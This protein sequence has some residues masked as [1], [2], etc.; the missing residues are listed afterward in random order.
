M[1]ITYFKRYRMEYDLSSKLFPVPPLPDRF[2]LVAWQDELL[3]THSETKYRSFRLEIDA[4]VFP[5]LGDREGC[6]RLMTEISSRNG[7]LP[8]STWLIGYDSDDG[9]PEYCGTVQGIRDRRGY[10][11]IQNLGIVPER[12]GLGL[13][14]IL[15][16]RS[17]VGFARMGL[18]KATLEVTAQNSGALRLYHRLGFRTVK[19]VYKAVE[20]AY[21]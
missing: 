13:G 20:V 12:R 3:Q 14:T 7:F 5:C 15:L 19:T 8:E 11:S 6:T 1:G 9:A 16:H 18:P 17:L 10:G 4:N 2:G 21:A